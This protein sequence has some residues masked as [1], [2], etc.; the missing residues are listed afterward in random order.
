MSGLS[1]MVKYSDGG[2]GIVAWPHK[3]GQENVGNRG[4]VITSQP[5]LIVVGVGHP[6]QRDSREM[7]LGVVS[8]KEEYLVLKSKVEEINQFHHMHHDGMEVTYEDA[9]LA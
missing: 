8:T 6:G 7:D 1:G 5:V 2:F 9:Y 4:R 3:K